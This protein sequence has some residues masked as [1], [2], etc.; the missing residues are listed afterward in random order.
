MYVFLRVQPAYPG[1]RP[2]SEAAPQFSRVLARNIDDL[3]AARREAES[4][5]SVQEHVSDAITRFTGSLRFVYFHAR[6][7]CRRL[8][9]RR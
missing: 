1:R 3:L 6:R 8:R 2:E 9:A 7:S 4:C 5:K